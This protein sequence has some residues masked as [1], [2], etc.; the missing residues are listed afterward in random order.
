MTP[1]AQQRKAL[2]AAV[3]GAVAA[4]SAY[5]LQGGDLVSVET[6]VAGLATAVVAYLFAFWAPNKS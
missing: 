5:A 4:V 2:M 3:G 1:L 6:A